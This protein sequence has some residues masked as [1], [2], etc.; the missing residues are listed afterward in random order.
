MN[1]AHTWPAGGRRTATPTPLC[2][3]GAYAPQTPPKRCPRRFA[4]VVRHARC[5]TIIHDTL[6]IASRSP[7]GLGIDWVNRVPNEFIFRSTF[8][9]GLIQRQF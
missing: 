5:I 1:V 2:I 9:V 4:P 6:L 7:P 3:L 8:R